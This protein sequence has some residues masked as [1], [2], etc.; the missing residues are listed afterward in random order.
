MWG[1]L[2]LCSYYLPSCLTSS[3][4]GTL[5]P[6]LLPRSFLRWR[7]TWCQK[8]TTSWATDRMAG[9]TTALRQGRWSTK[10]SAAPTCLLYHYHGPNHSMLM[11]VVPSLGTPKL[12]SSPSPCQPGTDG[13]AKLSIASVPVLNLYQVHLRPS[14]AQ[15]INAFQTQP[16]AASNTT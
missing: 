14:P 6:S 8:L 2:S 11:S 15:P 16:F 10:R 7:L 9:R 12:S 3:L 1:S 5:N 13:L 4:S